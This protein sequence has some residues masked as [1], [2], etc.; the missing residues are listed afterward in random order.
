MSLAGL[1]HEVNDFTVAWGLNTALSGK[2]TAA[3][4][5]H[6]AARSTSAAHLLCEE[7]QH[8]YSVHAVNRHTLSGWLCA[9]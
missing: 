3:L 2:V 8:L 4:S 7:L 9:M 1:T 5:A 6:R